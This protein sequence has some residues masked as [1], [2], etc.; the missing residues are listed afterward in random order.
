MPVPDGPII[1]PDVPTTPRR[2]LYP[3]AFAWLLSHGEGV[4]RRLYGAHKERLLTSLTGVVVEIG[5]GA[6]LNLR[7][8]RGAT[9]YVAVEPNVHFHGRIRR[10]A[11]RAGVAA[12]VTAGLAERLP[13][14]D[15]SADAVIS[16]LVLCSVSDPRA[17]LAEVRRVLRPGGAFVFIEHV[18]ARRG[19]PLRLAQAAFRPLWGAIADGCRPDR[20]TVR[21]VEEAGFAE[22]RVE[23][24]AGPPGLIR[25]HAAGVARAA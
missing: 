16:T 15:A 20:E 6:G 18:A 9:R 1:R 2:G 10:R 4:D 17:A 3:R 23:R 24:F 8:L 14:A 7:Y 12:E 25:P 11:R 13:L 21:L 19:T 5:P 22:V